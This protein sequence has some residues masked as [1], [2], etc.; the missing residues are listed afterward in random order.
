[1][2][3][4]TTTTEQSPKT[5]TEFPW[6]IVLHD[7]Q[8]DPYLE[9]KIKQDVQKIGRRLKNFHPDLVH[10]KIDIWRHPRRP[11]F[12]VRLTLRV[13]SNIL[14]AERSNKDLVLAMNEAT[15]ALIE[16][17]DALKSELRREVFWKRKHRRAALRELKVQGFTAEPMPSGTGPQTL[18]AMV[19]ALF[20]QHYDQILRHV[21]RHIRHDETIGAIPRGAVSPMEIVDE[22]AVQV[23]EEAEKKPANMSWLVWFY[24]LA[25][26]KLEEIRKHYAQEKAEEVPAEELEP[27]PAKEEWLEEPEDS[28]TAEPRPAE[29]ERE[30]HLPEPVVE[31]S[32]KPD[33]EVER[34][35]MLEFLQKHIQS[36]SK[37]DRQVFEL[38]Y[39]EGFEPDEIAMILGVKPTT[40]M[41]RLNEL[42]NRIRQL[43]LEEAAV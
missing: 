15:R 20:E 39:V 28:S 37:L 2:T 11:R 27:A 22:L 25:H 30:A 32:G 26:K 18:G 34:K 43:L 42:Q 21:R 41:R 38:Y 19:R 1:M 3:T 14:H 29:E 10:L 23:E 40:V 7:V 17:L 24:H 33:Q 4:Q 8:L 12:H 16:E 9:K 5:Q 35:D 6:N 36:W 31:P 13:P